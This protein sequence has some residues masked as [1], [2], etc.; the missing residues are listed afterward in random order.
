MAH[1]SRRESA[2]SDVKLGEL[3]AGHRETD[4]A[5]FTSYGLPCVILRHRDFGHLCGYVGVPESNPNY[6][7]A[8]A[9][10][11]CYVHGG[12]TYAADKLREYE[13]HKKLWWIGFDCSHFG[14]A[15][16]NLSIHNHGT[17][18]DANYVEAECRK[19]AAQLADRG[20]NS[21]G[22]EPDF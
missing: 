17:Y 11:H 6:G 4:Y 8:D 16:P 9:E 15:M 2:E 21:D 22:R 1:K 3:F 7:K 13:T 20:G 12:V 10:L 5:T 19:L 18:R 14:D